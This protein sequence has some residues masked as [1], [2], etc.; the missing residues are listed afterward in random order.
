MYR[1]EYVPRDHDSLN[2]QDTCGHVEEE[3]E[4]KNNLMS[5][6]VE[7]RISQIPSD[8]PKFNKIWMN[9]CDLC[10]VELTFCVISDG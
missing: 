6:T 2:N 8:Y 9:N 7:H 4:H 10:A 5:G 1:G 3:H